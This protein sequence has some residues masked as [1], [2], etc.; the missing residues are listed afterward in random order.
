MSRTLNLTCV[1]CNKTLWVGQCSLSQ[2]WYLYTTDR[3][4][5][6]ISSFIGAH[7]G[8]TVIFDDSDSVI[9]SADD[10]TEYQ[11]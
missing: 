4:K 6:S 1:A 7:L 8:H 2:G 11:E 3:M 9:D 5:S 10:V